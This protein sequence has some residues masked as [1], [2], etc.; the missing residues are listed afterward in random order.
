MHLHAKSSMYLDIDNMKCIYL[1]IK[2][3]NCMYLDIKSS[4]SLYLDVKIPS[5]NIYMLKFLSLCI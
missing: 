4:K 1:D 2:N 5:P 3:S